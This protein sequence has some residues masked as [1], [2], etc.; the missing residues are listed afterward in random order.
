M[1]SVR[2]EHAALQ[3]PIWAVVFLTLIC[4]AIFAMSSWR[5]WSTRNAELKNTEIDMANLAQSLAQHAADTFELADTVLNGVVHRLEVDGNGRE[6]IT[7]LQTFID[8]RRPKLGR[9]RGLF[10]YDETGRWLATTEPVSLNG[11]NNS[12]REYFRRHAESDDRG[13]LIGRP[14]K[15]VPADNGSLPPQSVSTIQTAPLRASCWPP[16]TSHTS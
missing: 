10:V 7:R 4:V 5:E 9:I 15:V 8:M 11:L 6:A 13:L 2:R 16:L 14:V 1:S 12:D 3:L